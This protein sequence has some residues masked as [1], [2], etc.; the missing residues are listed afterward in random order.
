[1]QLSSHYFLPGIGIDDV[2]PG[3]LEAIHCDKF[4]TH[5]TRK[6]FHAKIVLAFVSSN[7]VT[8]TTE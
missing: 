3:H 1:M 7:D 5:G 6:N 8:L 4:I 2:G